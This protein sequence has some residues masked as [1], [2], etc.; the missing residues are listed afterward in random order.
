ML[1]PHP[2]VPQEQVQVVSEVGREAKRA[3]KMGIDLNKVYFTEDL[4][5]GKGLIFAASG[6]TDG[7]L[8]KGVRF[9]GGGFRIHSLV[10]TSQRVIR[11]IDSIQAS[12]TVQTI[13]LH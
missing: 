13:E 7:T 8:L 9:F 2:K 3:R 4:A 10:M 6:I 11:F 1:L 5:P 12:E